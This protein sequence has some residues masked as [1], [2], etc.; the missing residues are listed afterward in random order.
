MHV[1]MSLVISRM[2]CPHEKATLRISFLRLLALCFAC[3]MC[4]L[5]FYPRP[6]QDIDGVRDAVLV[7]QVHWRIALE[8]TSQTRI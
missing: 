3:A 2:Q 6:C 5:C 7:Q 8:S 1:H 4:A